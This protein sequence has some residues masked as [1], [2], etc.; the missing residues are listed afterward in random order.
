VRIA[1]LG[2]GIVGAT[3]GSK[4]VSLGHDV[5][6]GSR[7]AA[8]PK[9]AEWVATTGGKATAAA[10]ADAAAGAELVVNAT[11]GLGSLEALTAAGADNLAG[12]VLLDIANSLDFSRGM[13]PTLGVCNTD[14]LGEQIQRAFPQARVVKSLNT[15]TA[16]VMV[17]P[18]LVRGPH[19]VFLSGDDDSAKGVVRQLL[20]SI[21][22]PAGD[23]IDLGGIQTARGVEMWLPLWVSL[24]GATGTPIFN[25]A[26]VRG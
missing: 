1:V 6:M 18:S 21:G 22:W 9:A 8:N 11:A 12:K 19:S 24:M 4:L 15:M 20:E 16:A 17:Q 26:I 13:P 23:I 10:Y 25:L 14:S 2:T 5:V 3:V 7:D